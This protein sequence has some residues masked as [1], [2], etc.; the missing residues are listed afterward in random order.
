MLGT[1]ERT[2]ELSELSVLPVTHQAQEV[3]GVRVEKMARRKKKFKIT[4]I[5]RLK[6]H[7]TY[8]KYGRNAFRKYWEFVRFGPHSKSR[9]RLVKY[10]V[11]TVG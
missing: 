7:S 11:F 10:N 3:A 5:G 4:F 1:S 2:L 8:A 9:F 6:E